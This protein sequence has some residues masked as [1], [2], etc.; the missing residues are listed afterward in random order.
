M[1]LGEI[2][3]EVQVVA[4]EPS[5][6]D[7]TFNTLIN[8]A[9]QEVCYRVILPSLK[10][11]D[12]FSTTAGVAYGTLTGLTGG[13]SGILRRVVRA[14]DDEVISI[15]ATLEELVDLYPE[16]DTAGDVEAVVLEG[17]TLWYQ[18]VPATAQSLRVYYTA[19]PTSLSGDGDSPSHLPDYLHRKLLV[20]G[21]AR[22]VWEQIETDIEQPKVQTM[23][24]MQNFED[25]IMKLREHLARHR[26]HKITSYWSV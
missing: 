14:D 8:E 18:Y 11:Y 5:F 13:F 16:F 24:H 17:S 2:R 1:N 22:L 20:S 6:S 23:F 10:G 21:A 3:A 12:S 25:G 19:N 15:Y 7:S 26:K 4:P 9:Y